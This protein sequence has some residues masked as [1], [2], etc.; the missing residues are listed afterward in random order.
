MTSSP[1][2]IFIGLV[3]ETSD[4]QCLLQRG[5][6]HESQTGTGTGTGAQ[7]AP[8]VSNTSCC[9]YWHVQA[10]NWETIRLS[11]VETLA[12]HHDCGDV[13]TTPVDRG[14]VALVQPPISRTNCPLVQPSTNQNQHPDRNGR[15]D[16]RVAHQ[17]CGVDF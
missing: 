11:T 5:S 3:L 7:T 12:E 6:P 14:G 16:Q 8:L 2:F 13:G 9:A 17:L 4:D 15:L 1:P 10:N